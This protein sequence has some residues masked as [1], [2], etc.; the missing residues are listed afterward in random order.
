MGLPPSVGPVRSSSFAPT[1]ASA[2]W[3][4]LASL[5]SPPQPL[6]VRVAKCGLR[7]APASASRPT[8]V[9]APLRPPLPSPPAA[10]FARLPSAP[11]HSPPLNRRGRSPPHAS[12]DSIPSSLI[13]LVLPFLTAYAGSGSHTPRT[14]DAGTAIRSL[15]VQLS[16]HPPPLGSLLLLDRV[17]APCNTTTVAAPRSP[18]DGCRRRY[19]IVTRPSSPPLAHIQADPP[20]SWPPDRFSRGPMATE[21]ASSSP[22]TRR[23]GSKE[24]LRALGPSS[25]P[26]RVR[27]RTSPESIRH[28]AR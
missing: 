4:R 12:P 25:A 11:P 23:S 9:S 28:E 16:A 13:P 1:P 26:H 8:L 7:P 17:V 19:T 14:S 22:W 2:S 6:C 15:D 20:P 5:R 10:C 27:T 18:G 24:E 21:T 3:P